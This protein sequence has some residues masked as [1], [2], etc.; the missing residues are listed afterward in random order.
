MQ[1]RGLAKPSDD[2]I[3]TKA[4]R[5]DESYRNYSYEY[6]DSEKESS[7]YEAHSIQKAGSDSRSVDRAI[8]ILLQFSTSQL[9]ANDIDKTKLVIAYLNRLRDSVA[10]ASPRKNKIFVLITK[11]LANFLRTCSPLTQPGQDLL[12]EEL[13]SP[14]S[15]DRSNQHPSVCLLP[16]GDQ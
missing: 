11:S 2:W 15:V 4:M 6:K 14:A 7:K 10:Y 1:T 16:I 8:S 3:T 12:P 9:F 13:R 5:Q